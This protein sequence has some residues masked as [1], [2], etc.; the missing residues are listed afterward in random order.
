M[1]EIVKRQK[2]AN[3]E[4]NYLA[5]AFEGLCYLCALRPDNEIL[6]RIFNLFIQI[7][8]RCIHNCLFT[9]KQRLDRTGTLDVTA[10]LDISCHVWSGILVFSKKRFI[11][12]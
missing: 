12:I 11:L 8:K 4:T 10:R 1:I 9:F 5:V 2:F 3:T 6:S 7:E